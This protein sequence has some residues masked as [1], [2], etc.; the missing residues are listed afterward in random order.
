M[1]YLVEKHYSSVDSNDAEPQLN[2]KQGISCIKVHLH[3][4]YVELCRLGML[5][6][7]NRGLLGESGEE[8]YRSSMGR[9]LSLSI[10]PMLI[11]TMK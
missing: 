10:P 11:W 4:L 1:I 2:N 9:S 5:L 6:L 8:A 7:H 3:A